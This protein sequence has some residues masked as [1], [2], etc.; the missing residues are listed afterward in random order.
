MVLYYLQHKY[1]LALLTD[2]VT[3]QHVTKC[4]EVDVILVETRCLVICLSMMPI[5]ISIVK[6]TRCTSF[7][8]I[9]YFVVALYM[10]RTVFPY[11]ARS[12]RLYIQHQVY[13]TNRFCL[14]LASGNEMFHLVPA[15][16]QSTKSV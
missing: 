3:K 9:F 10:F 6:L 1:V 11:I 16:K 7:S 4:P 14:L 5:D 8:N 13:V 15:S 12:L 2:H